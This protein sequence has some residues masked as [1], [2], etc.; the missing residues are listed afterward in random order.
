M[1]AKLY[2]IGRPKPTRMNCRQIVD[3]AMLEMV[4]RLHSQGLGRAEVALALADASEE[5]VIRLASEAAH[6][7]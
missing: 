3:A 7:A 6:R 4:E 2:F 5:Y 1:T